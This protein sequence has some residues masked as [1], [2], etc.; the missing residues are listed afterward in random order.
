M[1]SI[2]SK[3]HH[4]WLSL[5][6]TSK[7]IV[8]IICAIV[9]IACSSVIKNLIFS[10][11]R[12]I[13]KLLDKLST[14]FKKLKKI[15]IKGGGIV[16]D[17]NTESVI[18]QENNSYSSHRD[19]PKYSEVVKMFQERKELDREVRRI[20]RQISKIEDVIILKEQMKHAE[21]LIEE[22]VIL[23]ETTFNKL[24]KLN[25][26]DDDIFARKEYRIYK[27]V[28][29]LIKEKLIIKIRLMCRDNHFAEKTE[30]E[31]AAYIKMQDKL[32]QSFIREKI[33]FYFPYYAEIG[34]YELMDDVYVGI[35]NTIF[36]F[37]HTAREISKAKRLEIEE[38]ENEIDAIEI[39][40]DEKYR[41]IG[42]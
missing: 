37:F 11:Q 19:C 12:M 13:S 3:M 22:M 9:V 40:Y 23:A 30:S 5:D 34:N 15:E 8:L 39:A 31:F 28:L 27:G 1:I 29:E 25:N 14:F 24:L 20:Y 16:F 21:Y 17:A 36:S 35:S 33:N 7:I 4:I 18:K 42:I 6:I 2:L 41:I 38:L 32:I 26:A 10:I